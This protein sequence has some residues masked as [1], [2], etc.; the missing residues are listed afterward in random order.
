MSLET[1]HTHG[2]RGRDEAGEDRRAAIIATAARLFQERGYSGT[3]VRDLAREV[4]ITSGSIFHHFGSK[5]EVLL[6]VVEKGLVEATTRMSGADAG[7]PRARLQDMIHAHLSALLEGAPETLSVLFHER[8]ALSEDAR[9]RLIEMRDAYE[10]L[11]DAALAALGPP[12]DD[13]SYRRLNRLL[14]MGSMNW[15]A[16]WY[17]ADGEFGVDDVSL[18]LYKRY[19]V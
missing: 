5:E 17:R 1:N 8:R 16:Q 14:L 4:G 6:S 18:A 11:W 19:V 15:C 3:T 9:T 10:G 7:E 13:A 12:Y 2:G